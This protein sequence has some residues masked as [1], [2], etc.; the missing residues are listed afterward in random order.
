[1]A[2][3]YNPEL[4]D[5]ERK[6]LE[7]RR[8]GTSYDEIAVALGYA[9]GAGAWNAVQRAMKRTLR[10]SGADEV[11]DQE[12]DRLD[13]LQRAVWVRALQG[14]LPAVGAV[15]RIMERRSKMLGLDAPITAN[16][17]VEHFD[18]QTVDAEVQRIIATLQQKPTKQ[19][20]APIV[21]AE[22]IEDEQQT[23]M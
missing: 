4:F 14:D 15:L 5:K 20:A 18:G 7:L 21:D 12:L 17:A 16:I 9:K 8:A 1:M 3:A 2:R 13:R 10:E 11:R 6:A 22:V 23:D 19:L